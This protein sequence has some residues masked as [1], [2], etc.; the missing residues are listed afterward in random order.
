LRGDRTIEQGEPKR[1]PEDFEWKLIVDREARVDETAVD[2]ESRSVETYFRFSVFCV[3]KSVD[4][5]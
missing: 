3:R 4:G 1:F 2:P 5:E